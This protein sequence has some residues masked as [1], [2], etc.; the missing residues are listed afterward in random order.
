MLIALV[1]VLAGLG[2]ILV[3]GREG[4]VLDERSRA[5]AAETSTTTTTGSARIAA[6]RCRGVGIPIDVDPHRVLRRHAAGTTFCLA[7]GVHRLSRPL[8]PQSGDALVGR[9]GAVLN[10]S[11]VLTGWQEEDGRWTTS[12]RL[13]PEPSDHGE[14]LTERPGCTLSEDVFI[15]GQRLARVLGVE[16]V[17][18]GSFYAD[19]DRNT[20][21]VGDDPEGRLVE[22]AV[23]PALVR[24][25]GDRVTVR[26]LIIEKA[27]NE[28]QAAAV[29]GRTVS[30]RTGSGWRV[31][32]NVVRLNHGV[33]IGVGSA[34]VVRGNEVRDQGQLG[35]SVW[36]KG[37]L[38]TGNVLAGNGVAG[39]DSEWE[40]GGLKAW[41]TE[42]VKL[43]GNDVH[44][45]RG[46]GLWS[47]GGC[48]RTTYRRNVVTANWGAG[49]Q[50]EIS[51]DA[52][53]VRNRLVDNGRRHKGWA[54]EA[55]IQIQSSGG[56]G[57][58]AVKRN[59]VDGNANGI[60][61]IQSGDRRTEWPA[62]HGPHVVR[63]VLVRRNR[64]SMHADQWTGLVHDIGNHD[65]FGRA[66]RFRANTYEVD[67]G[68]AR[69]F[70][71]KDDVLTFGEWQGPRADQD[72]DG[73][74]VV[75]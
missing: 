17:A 9:P 46:P 59:V 44:D 22:Q 2:A 56:L 53:I 19:Y 1:L 10:G 24:S 64:V 72:R 25:A 12:G 71:W 29:D 58:I 8:R 20:I 49:I 26:G 38:I 47:D 67:T 30:P 4:R 73:T 32:G 66:I 51:Y 55:G 31:V 28:A 57:I 33:G 41:E 60:M 14:C 69:H 23:A 52:L 70:A 34:G 11:A 40:A 15:D 50:H 74:L 5:Q 39:Y 7:A 45:N 37:A 62:P 54:W 65:V 42:N 3:T 18:T 21:T 35:V 13:P 63:N 43:V 36:E 68:S 75:R 61:V 6:G 48:H 16:E 27:A